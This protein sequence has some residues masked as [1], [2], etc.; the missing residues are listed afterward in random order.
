VEVSER[1]LAAAGSSVLMHAPNIRNVNVTEWEYIRNTT[2]EFILQYYVDFPA[3]TIYPAYQGRVVFYQ[4]NGSILLQ[5]VQETDSGIYK[6]TVDLMQ[7]KART[8]LLE[9]IQPVPQPEIQHS[10]NLA[11]SVIELVCAV[12]EG[13]VVDSVFWKK[14]GGPLPPE[15]CYLVP[16]HASVLR[17]RGGEKS[18]CGSYSCNV[19]NRIS[20]KE[21]T[22]NLTLTGLTSPLLHGQRLV[23]TA[24]MFTS[25][26]VISF[27]VLLCRLRVPTFGTEV[28]RHLALLTHVLLCISSLLMLAT[29]IIWLQEDGVSPAFILLGLFFFRYQVVKNPTATTVLTV[30]LLFST[31]FL[32]NI[33][34]LHE[35]GCSEAV[36]LLPSCVSA[37]AAISI[38]LVLLLL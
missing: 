32:H 16:G 26:S 6:A 14:E 30:N 23:V 5:G 35:R 2:H 27:I 13:A 31:L 17:I 9:V 7:D 8:T 19:S 22:L 1:R 33:Q 21:T 15:K 37:A 10:S 29:S 12:P 3:P 28:W 11:G 18:D 24:L 4:K 36:D 34:Q 20:W 25:V 38:L